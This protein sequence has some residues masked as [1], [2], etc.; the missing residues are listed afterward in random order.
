MTYADGLLQRDWEFILKAMA[1]CSEVERAVLFGSR[2]MGNFRSG[3][4]VDLAVYGTSVTSATLNQLDALL[5]EHYPL[6][7][8]FDVLRFESISNDALRQHIETE[9]REVYRRQ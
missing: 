8:Q 7:Y 2:A 4:D 3:S 6:P 5:N 9:G 1:Q